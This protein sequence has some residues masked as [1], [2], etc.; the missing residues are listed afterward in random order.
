MYQAGDPPQW[1][2]GDNYPDNI[3]YWNDYVRYFVDHGKGLGVVW[4]IGNEPD[5][6]LK[7]ILGGSL[8]RT[9]E[10]YRDFAWS[11]A[12]IIREVDPESEIIVGS[13]AGMHMGESGYP[14]TETAFKKLHEVSDIFGIHSYTGPRIVG[15]DKSYISPEE[16]DNRGR[17]RETFDM[18]DKYS[19]NHVIWNTECGYA[20][21]SYN[22]AFIDTYNQTFTSLNARMFITSFSVPGVEK[23]FHFRTAPFSRSSGNDYGLF[24]NLDNYPRPLIPMF[25]HMA[26]VM[27]HVE[28]LD[29][30]VREDDFQI[31]PFRTEDGKGLVVAYKHKGEPETIILD[32]SSEEL[33]VTDIMGNELK[34]NR[35]ENKSGIKLTKQPV[36]I[37]SRTLSAQELKNLFINASYQSTQLVSIRNVYF[38]SLDTLN[39]SLLNNTDT[40]VQAMVSVHAPQNLGFSEGENEFLLQAG[41]TR[42]VRIPGEEIGHPL[43]IVNQSI[44]VKAET[45]D[46]TSE[47]SYPLNYEPINYTKLPVNTGNLDSLKT[48]LTHF[49]LRGKNAVSPP[50]PGIGWDDNNDLSSEIYLGWDS[51]N[52]YLSAEVNDDVHHNIWSSGELKKGDALLVSFDT[53]NDALALEPGYDNNDYEIV[54]ALVNESVR[55]NATYLPE[56]KDTI[57]FIGQVKAE[58]KRDNSRTVYQITLPWDALYEQAISPNTILGVNVA[59]LDNDN[60][61][62]VSDYWNE[63]TPGTVE[64]NNPSLY[65]KFITINNTNTYQVA[66]QVKD[67]D[68]GK[69]IEDCNLS[70]NNRDFQTSSEGEIMLQDLLYGAYTVELSKEGY[71]N[72]TYSDI[73]IFSDTTITLDMQLEYLSATLKL[74][75]QSNNEPVNMALVTTNNGLYRSNSEGEVKIDAL[76][77]ETQLYYNVDANDFFDYEDSV[78]I[79]NDTSLI[80]N[81]YSKKVNVEFFVKNGQDPVSNASVSLGGSTQLSNYLGYILFLNK[82]ARSKYYYT[83]SKAGYQTI[84]DS[85]YLEIDTTLSISLEPVT[86][87]MNRYHSEKMSIYPNPANGMIHVVFNEPDSEMQI[88]CLNGRI[89]KEM[90][91]EPGVNSIDISAL[92]EGIYVIKAISKN[93]TVYNLLMIS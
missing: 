80:V 41:E 40:S 45:R 53:R 13:T 4:E 81:L 74:Q 90:K 92:H 54:T 21:D 26:W 1:A 69:P 49:S 31:F 30:P 38:N 16:K 67:S 11:A 3:E 42:M 89:M 6:K 82:G 9:G 27:H 62:G 46:A 88:V 52:L 32:V 8:E 25:S 34:I 28:P 84:N 72:M 20:I 5:L 76:R 12:N 36:Y 37:K 35:P 79:R 57:S 47:Y 58:I 93:L 63:I 71:T 68:T 86:N 87:R 15:K 44:L 65:K 39:V 64:S 61:G 73:K 75:D 24:R 51:L 29:N 91:L 7:N 66:F 22:D 50:D 48:S 59:V 70:I 18:I 83:I 19:N 77:P 33:F 78:F 43:E 60:T 55:L 23:V 2:I 14:Y 17:F 56:G 85:L 10:V